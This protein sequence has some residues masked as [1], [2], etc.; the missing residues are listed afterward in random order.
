MVTAFQRQRER[1][2]QEKIQQEDLLVKGNQD[3]RFQPLLAR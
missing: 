2:G 1:Q 3:G